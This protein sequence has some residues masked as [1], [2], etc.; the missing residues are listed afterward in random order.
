MCHFG[1]G[2]DGLVGL[3]GLVGFVGLLL[4]P[5]YHIYP[6][7]PLRSSIL[8]YIFDEDLLLTFFH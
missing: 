6:Y 8:Q 2:V 5:L 3:V 7:I 4:F 1:F